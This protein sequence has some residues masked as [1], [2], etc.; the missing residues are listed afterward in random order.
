M[1]KLLLILSVLVVP[2]A[3][4]MDKKEGGIGLSGITQPPNSHEQLRERLYF[5]QSQKQTIIAPTSMHMDKREPTQKK[6]Q[7]QVKQKTERTPD[8]PCCCKVLCCCA[9][10]CLQQAVDGY[11]AESYGKY[12]APHETMYEY[13]SRIGWPW[14]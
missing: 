13:Y 8:C 10:F 2:A 11:I 7:S 5:Q 3:L 14:N 9:L 6:S 12:A 4:A 1:K